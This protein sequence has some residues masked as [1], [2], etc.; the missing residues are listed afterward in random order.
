[1]KLKNNKKGAGFTDLFVFLVSAFVIALA[2]AM[3]FYIGT[4]TN[5]AL[6]NNSEIFVKGM[7]GNRSGSDIVASTF[8]NVPNAYES[9]KWITVMLIVG[10]ALSIIIS[11]FLVSTRPVFFVVYILVWIIAIVVSVPMSNAYETVY[12]TPS[13]T[14]AF[15]GFWG[16]TFI[17]LNL[18][19]WITVIGGLSGIIMF[20]NMVRVNRFGGYA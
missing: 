8:G 17:F 15:A 9:L 3:F 10:M 7:S 5:E 16:Q 18:P 12:Q 14:R 6:Q 13:L 11:S 19:V 1:M 4:I 20:V 2:C